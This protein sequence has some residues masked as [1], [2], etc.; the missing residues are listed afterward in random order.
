LGVVEVDETFVGGV[1]KNKHKD[2]RGG[3]TGGVG[4]GKSVVVCAVQHKGNVV[5][6]VIELPL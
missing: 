1:A 5:A 2:R 3:G 6:C 4:S